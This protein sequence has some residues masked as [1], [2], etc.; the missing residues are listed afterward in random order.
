[1]V[2]EDQNEARGREE[3][4]VW[5]VKQAAEAAQCAE[6]QDFIRRSERKGGDNGIV[7]TGH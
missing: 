2:D 7:Q 4:L 3:W 5:L 6:I 1:M